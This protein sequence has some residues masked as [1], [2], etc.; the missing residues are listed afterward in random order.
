MPDSSRNSDSKLTSKTPKLDSGTNSLELKHNKT[1]VQLTAS[2]LESWFAQI[3][4]DL[5]KTSQPVQGHTPSNSGNNSYLATQFVSRFGLKTAA[6]VITFL[7]SPAGK[8]TKA[9]IAEEL[10]EIAAQREERLFQLRE[11]EAMRHRL[12]A[13][14]FLGLLYKREAKAHQLNNMLAE[15]IDSHLRK[16]EKEAILAEN[17]SS[18]SEYPNFI[19]EEIQAYQ[20]AS[21]A[22]EEKLQSKIAMSEALEAEIASVEEQAA[23]I[24]N[25]YDAYDLHIKDIENEIQTHLN[26][27]ALNAASSTNTPE[28]EAT[29]EQKIADLETRSD[30]LATE[31][32]QDFDVDDDKRVRELV[33]RH[34]AVNI[35]VVNLKDMLSVIQGKKVLYNMKGEQASSFADADFILENDKKI[36]LHDGKFHLLQA[37]QS[38]EDLQ[39][40][41]A[42]KAQSHQAYQRIKPDIMSVKKLVEHNRILEEKVL[43]EKKDPLFLRSEAM[44]QDIMLLT[45]QLTKIQAAHAMAK[46]AQDPTQNTPTPRPSMSPHTSTQLPNPKLNNSQLTSYVHVALLME[47]NKG[48]TTNQ[49]QLS[50][51]PAFDPADLNA[52]KEFLKSGKPIPHQTMQLMLKNMERFGVD[53]TKSFAHSIAPIDL[54]KQLN[55]ADKPANKPA[56]S[57]AFNPTPSPFKTRR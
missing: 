29:I 20:K 21:I 56:E 41:E 32:F 48:L 8:S 18:S 4:K 16:E 17:K 30:Q 10:A 26:V 5:F 43:S 25:K 23:A 51:N 28:I 50:T 2:K 27:P 52:M 3:E 47:Q 39:Q 13:F 19:N 33:D 14:L 38:I 46:S 6:D 36:V 22:L 11:H 34:N 31:M 1:S 12:L 24:T 49:P 44:Q 53:A 57:P 37:K 7:K 40:N 15:E 55:P 45:N 35:Q 54:E 42:L 9:L